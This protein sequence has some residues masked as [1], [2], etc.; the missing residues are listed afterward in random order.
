MR[1]PAKVCAVGM[2]VLAVLSSA[3]L[4]VTTL[5]GDV[6]GFGFVN[7]NASWQSAQNTS[8]D[9]DGDGVIESGEYLPDLD[10]DGAV[11]VGG[12]DEF[13]NRSVSE[14]AA[15]NGAQWTDISLEDYYGT[16]GD[17]PADDA[18]FNF[19]F[20]VPL[21]GDSDYGVDH[22]INV[23]FGDYD[24]SPMSITVD[25]ATVPLTAQSGGN[26][27]LVQLAYA[28]VPW[29]DMTD[30]QVNIE[31]YAP[32]EPYVTLDYAYLSTEH[33][34]APDD[35]VPAPGAVLLGTLGAGLVGWMRRRRTL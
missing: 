4:G 18:F 14:Q 13:D 6:D 27:G 10:N 5:I 3:A 29:V 1:H 15:T 23:L 24:V 7:P 30:G 25:G 20:A 19:T 17:S 26:D 31:I 8:P 32:S 35:C 34:S 11:H 16:F 2:L 28:T 12:N 22:Y 21:S 33:G 9:T